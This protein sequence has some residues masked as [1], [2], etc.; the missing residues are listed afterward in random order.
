[1]KILVT[2]PLL[3]ISGYGNHSRQVLEAMQH[4]HLADEI[5]CNVSSWGNSTWSVG[6]EHIDEDLFEFITKNYIS[7]Q[8]LEE[9][10][11][12]KKSKFDVS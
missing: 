11:K 6:R 3:S 7:D 10:K 2:G 4:V 8:E 5:Y 12:S 1:M 9:I